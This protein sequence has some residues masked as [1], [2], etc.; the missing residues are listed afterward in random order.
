[1]CVF[2]LDPR[3]DVIYVRKVIIWRVAFAD[4]LTVIP[5]KVAALKLP[6]NLHFIIL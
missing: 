5:G 6:Q 3:L 1:M 4:R 2:R